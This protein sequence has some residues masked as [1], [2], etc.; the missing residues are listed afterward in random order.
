MYTLRNLKQLFKMS[1]F[2]LITL[3]GFSHYGTCKLTNNC[4]DIN[5][6]CR[7]KNSLNYFIYYVHLA[8]IHHISM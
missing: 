4:S 7:M 1:A 5:V 6:P 2:I 3:P 8:F